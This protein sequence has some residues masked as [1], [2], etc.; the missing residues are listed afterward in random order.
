MGRKQKSTGVDFSKLVERLK[1]ATSGELPELAGCRADHWIELDV[2]LGSIMI[3]ENLGPKNDWSGFTLKARWDG[4]DEEIEDFEVPFW[5]MTAFTDCIA[6]ASGVPDD[7]WLEMQYL[8]TFD[9]SGKN[10]AR[11][12]LA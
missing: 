8:R 4:E 2:N 12:R 1:E 9:Q 7:G 5:A 3:R 11:F 10:T 6:E